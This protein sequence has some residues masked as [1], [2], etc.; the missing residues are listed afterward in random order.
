MFKG[1]SAYKTSALAY[2]S[3][4]WADFMRQSSNRQTFPI[5]LAPRF[6]S[7]KNG[8]FDL[9]LQHGRSLQSVEVLGPPWPS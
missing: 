1:L 6:K 8:L 3:K 4:E 2:V 5:A 7:D 9:F